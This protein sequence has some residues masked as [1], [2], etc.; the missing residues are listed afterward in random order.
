MAEK[1]YRKLTIFIVLFPDTVNQWRPA[2]AEP[3]VR[4]G[5]F[6]FFILDVNISD[7][8]FGSGITAAAG[9][10]LPHIAVVCTLQMRSSLSA[11]RLL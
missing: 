11:A 9:T 7:R 1:K 5:F 3:L 8:N 4:E 2:T 6:F 10:Y